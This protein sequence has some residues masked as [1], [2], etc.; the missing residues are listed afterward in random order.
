MQWEMWAVEGN[1]LGQVAHHI[2]YDQ[3]CGQTGRQTENKQGEGS[4]AGGWGRTWCARQVAKFVRWER[5]GQLETTA[6]S[7]II[8]ITDYRYAC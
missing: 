5:E 2:F 7:R 6:T 4:L 8:T 3:V 1:A